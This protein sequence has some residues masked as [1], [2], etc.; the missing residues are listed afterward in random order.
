ML[1]LV[2]SQDSIAFTHSLLPIVTLSLVIIHFIQI[3]KQG[4][5]GPLYHPK[6][7]GPVTLLTK[8][9]CCCFFTNPWKGLVSPLRGEHVTLTP[10]GV[11]PAPKG[12]GQR[13]E[14]TILATI[15]AKTLPQN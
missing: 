5:S 3:R 15:L 4:I 1:V 12:A 11:K 13:K 6:I 14:A 10:L 9:S 2:G 8:K 7:R